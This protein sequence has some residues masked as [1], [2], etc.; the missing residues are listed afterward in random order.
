MIPRAR[1]AIADE[2]L[3][4][5]STHLFFLDADIGMDFKD[6]IALLHYCNEDMPIVTAPYPKKAIAWEKIWSAAHSGKITSP[7]DLKHFMADFVFNMA[8][9]KQTEFQLDEF[10]EIGEG[11]TGAMMI[12]RSALDKFTKAYPKQ[13]YESDHVRSSEYEKGRKLTAFF[14]TEID[15]KTK[16]YLSEDYMFSKYCRRIGIKIYMAPWMILQ[17][18]G[19]MI[20]EGDIGAIAS[21]GESPTASERSINNR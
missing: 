11:G 10:I 7:F 3:R 14:D 2:F 12:H 18:Q 19:S 15:P 1:N 8:D 16:R 17:H 9:S 21:I 4:S 13:R 6:I 5:D 20:F